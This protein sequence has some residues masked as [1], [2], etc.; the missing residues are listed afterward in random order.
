MNEIFSLSKMNYSTTSKWVSFAKIPYLANKRTPMHILKITING[1]KSNLSVYST[2]FVIQQYY[3]NLYFKIG[4]KANSNQEVEFKVVKETNGDR[5]I[6]AKCPPNCSI[7]TQLTHSSA[8]ELI[9]PIICDIPDK[10]DSYFND[11]TYNVMYVDSHDYGPNSGGY[12]YTRYSGGTEAW[13]GNFNLMFTFRGIPCVYYGS[14]IEFQ[15]NMQIEPY[16]NGNKVPYSQSGRA[17]FGDHLEG[18]VNATDFGE[19]TASGEVA[20]TLN[21]ELAQHLIR[22]NKIRRAIPALQKGQYSTEGCSGGISFK[23][24]YTDDSVDSFAL[25]A[26]GAQ[27]TFTGVPTGEYIEVITGKTVSCDGTLTSDSIEK[28]NMRVYVLKT[29]SCDITEQIGVAGAYLK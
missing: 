18:T 17:Y 6:Y 11:A 29:P 19:Y 8:P 25:V 16:T 9:L 20:N 24:R 26:I 22:L 13:A 15:K 4:N 28:D 5:V 1:T 14:E 10:N 23:R 2:D 3:N 21:Y 27:A 7:Y 12:L